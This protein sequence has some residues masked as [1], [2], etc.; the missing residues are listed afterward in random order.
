MINLL[1]KS[2]NGGNRIGNI[3][4]FMMLNTMLKILVSR[5]QAILSRLIASEKT[6]AVKVRTIKDN[7]QS[8]R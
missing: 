1:R 8:I 5:F 4:P 3:R 2:N 6:C 7:I